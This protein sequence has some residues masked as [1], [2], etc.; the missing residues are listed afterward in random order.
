MLTIDPENVT[1]EF[2]DGTLKHVGA[3]N[4]AATVKLYHA[5]SVEAR[6]FGDDRVKVAA[7]DGEGNA[8]EVSLDP[9]GLRALRSDLRA[10][11]LDEEWPAFD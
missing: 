3:P 6:P 8:V 11:D 2:K 7:E 4:A 1:V 5:E 10:L 9:D